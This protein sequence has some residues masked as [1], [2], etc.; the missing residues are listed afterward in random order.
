MEISI[1]SLVYLRRPGRI[2]FAIPKGGP[3]VGKLSSYGGKQEDDETI[4]DCAAR[5][6]SDEG[7]FKAE[8]N[9]LVKYG[10]MTFHW[11]TE[12]PGH[13][14]PKV[15]DVEVHIYELKKWVGNP[16]ESQ[17][18]GPL[19]WYFDD[20]AL[21]PFSLMMPGEDLWMGHF[22]AREPFTGQSWYFKHTDGSVSLIK[23]SL[24]YPPDRILLDKP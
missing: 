13:G 21:M 7:R 15:K 24:D 2:G 16:A 18:M 5:E 22:I 9:N 3:C 8:V 14:R 23:Q 20:P 19:E 11:N 17:E 12:V 1:C 10:V 6:T 4:A